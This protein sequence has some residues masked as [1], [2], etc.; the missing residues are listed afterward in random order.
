MYLS[1]QSTRPVMCSE[2]GG[3]QKVL[4]VIPETFGVH[5]RKSEREKGS[6]QDL[7]CS[8]VI[9]PDSLKPT[10]ENLGVEAQRDGGGEGVFGVALSTTGRDRRDRQVSERQSPSPR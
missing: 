2:L 10:M 3:S 5:W 7:L 4:G 6:S 9:V 1:P 8:Q